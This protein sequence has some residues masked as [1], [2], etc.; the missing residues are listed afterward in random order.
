MKQAFKDAYERELLLLKERAGLFAKD[1]PGLADR[2]GGL[3][4]ENLDPSI[5]GLLEGTAFL[6]A[7][8]QLNIDQQ[9]RTFSTELLEQICPDMT[10]PLP[11]AMM[12]QAASQAKPEDLIEGRTLPQG[13]YIE[14]TFSD[15]TR[16]IPCRFRLA[17]PVTFWPIKIGGAAYHATPTAL[18]AL[19]CDSAEVD[20]GTGRTAAGLV[21]DLERTDGKPFDGLAT[22]VL[23]IHFVGAMQEA[24][25]LYAQIFAGTVRASLRWEDDH[26]TP[27]F[28]RLPPHALQ[29]VGFDQDYPLYGR[30]ERQFPGVS[31]LLEFFAFS[32]KFLGCQLTGLAHAFSGIPASKI[33]LI[34][35]FERSNSYLAKHFEPQSLRLFCAPAVNLFEDDAKPISLDKHAHKLPV[36]PNR[37]PVTHYEVHRILGVRA[38]YESNRQKEPVLPLYGI[39][40]VEGATRDVRYYTY[41]REPRGLNFEERR[42]GG[43]RFRYEGTQTWLT[44]YEP[45]AEQD[46]KLLFVKVLCSNRHLPEVLSIADATFYLLDDR[47]VTL[48]PMGP[49]TAPREAVAELESDASHRMQAGDNYWRLI[50]LLSLSYRGFIAADGK[51]NVEAI[52][53][54]L[55]LFSDVSD[56]LTTAQINALVDVR[57]RHRARTLKR[58]GGFHPVRG[59]EITLT[60]DED[61][62][63]PALAI[64]LGAALDHF[65]ADY[66]AISTFTQCVIAN[67]KGKVLKTWPPRG[68]SGPLL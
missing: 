4:E 34:L 55:R 59:L 25:A 1:Y 53:E 15:A 30:D 17:E 58:A 7:R 36:A 42:A 14:A 44:Y 9:F 64:T 22:D 66:A 43:A 38:Q 54:I 39:P 8:V 21:V 18:N 56:Q 12:V 26:G 47:T 45:P 5:A 61:M 41:H 13:A 11:S 10:A 6:A 35:E 46:A 49:P 32:R 63:D 37:T 48:T 19:G 50:S 29:Q 62:L 16:R 28:K 27:T 24:T 65:L 40:P 67:T 52:R 60:F 68:G 33:K 23:P 3:M 20:G 31:K 2:L 57:A 51:G